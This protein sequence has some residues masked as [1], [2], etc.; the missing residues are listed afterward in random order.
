MLGSPLN[1]ARY[2]NCDFPASTKTISLL[3]TAE[4]SRRP[5]S[6]NPCSLDNPACKLILVTA[7]QSLL[8]GGKFS[9][10]LIRYLNIY[11][12][13]PSQG[14]AETYPSSSQYPFGAVIQ[15]EISISQVSCESDWFRTDKAPYPRQ[16]VH[17]SSSRPR[18]LIDFPGYRRYRSMRLF[19]FQDTR[20]PRSV[21]TRIK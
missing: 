5:P 12:S 1:G 7:G 4:T 9:F 11:L 21:V 14:K 3:T 18:N 19:L 10:L 6:L 16:P 20:Q 13:V 15:G 17:F 2:P 8:N